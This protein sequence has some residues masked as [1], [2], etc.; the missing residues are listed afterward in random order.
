MK[1]AVV[2][3][4]LAL[5][6]GF[7]SETSASDNKPQLPQVLTDVEA[8]IRCGYVDRA[9]S[10]LEDYL[11]DDKENAAAYDLLGYAQA[12][13]GELEAAAMSYDAA[14]VIDPQNVSALEHQGE[15][16]LMRSQP[17]L[18]ERNV[19][20]LEKLCGVSCYEY[21]SL[22]AMLNEYHALN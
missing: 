13:L 4:A 22:S 6:V 9:V 3:L 1:L 5:V 10:V 20:K 17:E 8:L 16:Y 7:A 11:R 2:G 21:R 18:A 19:V 12:E 15:L 14:L